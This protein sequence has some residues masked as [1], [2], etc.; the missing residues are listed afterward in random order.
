MKYV[1]R[2]GTWET[3]SSSEHCIVCTRRD[4]HLTE[5]E[6][7]REVIIHNGKLHLQFDVRE[8]YGRSP[9]RVLYTFIDKLSYLL[10]AFCGEDKMDNPDWDS[11]YDKILNIVTEI[12]PDV[13]DFDLK[14]VEEPIFMDKH[15]VELNRDE[16]VYNDGNAF[17]HDKE[18]NSWLMAKDTG[19]VMCYPVI[20]SIDHQSAG[21]LDRF[22]YYHGIDIKEFLLNKKYIVIVDGDEYNVYNSLVDSGLINENIIEEVF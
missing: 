11:N 21:V 5:E 4:M 19:M 20:G 16:V 10:C 15:G 12:L 22:L 6:L 8:G 3:N 14:E 1:I 18:M 9:F 17:Y 7:R 2:N 13:E